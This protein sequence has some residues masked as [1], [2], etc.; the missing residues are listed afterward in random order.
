MV[1]KINITQCARSGDDVKTWKAKKVFRSPSAKVRTFSLPLPLSLPLS[2][3][4]SVFFARNF[5]EMELCGGM[6][7]ANAKTVGGNLETKREIKR[8]KKR[9][10]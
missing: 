3:S 4:L 1:G 5:G 10:T 6:L 9:E 2:N 8:E 7:F